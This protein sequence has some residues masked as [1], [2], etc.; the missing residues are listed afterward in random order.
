MFRVV[1]RAAPVSLRAAP[2]RQSLASF[3]QSRAFTRT[4][5]QSPAASHPAM[6]FNFEN[7]S[8][9]PRAPWG[10]FPNQFRHVHTQPPGWAPTLAPPPAAAPP[11][12][13]PPVPAPA[14]PAPAPGRT[15]KY[16]PGTHG[17][18][19][20]EQKRLAEKFGTT[21]SGDTHESEHAIGFEPLN[22]TSDLKRGSPGR[23]RELENKAPAYQEVNELHRE[24][25]GTGTTGTVDESGFN[26]HTYRAAQRSLVE[27]GDVSSAVQL[28][29]L[30][31]AH[32]PGGVFANTPNTV[33][34]KQANDS[35][36]QM[37]G[38][39]S[40]VTYAQGNNNVTVPVDARQRAEIHLSRVAAQTG[41]FPSVSEENAVRKLYGLDEYEEQ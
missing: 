26:S 12:L 20:A 22:Q 17:F 6:G 21:V 30:G 32:L 15:R 19:K 4:T 16:P 33:P 39:L 18:K 3:Q 37:V 2:V 36:N 34:G 10:G 41:S 9:E 38:N 5:F 27:S 31:Y 13:V 7:V 14:P 23:A 35:F 29:Q 1:L 24:H 25:I 11:V 28:N 8:A 40:S